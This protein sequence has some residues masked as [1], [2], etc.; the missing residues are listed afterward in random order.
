MKLNIGCGYE[1]LP[2]YVNIDSSRESLADKFM[3]A[4]R[5]EFDDGSAG[6]VRAAQLIEHLGFFKAKY[7]LA[8]C[9]R[10][11]K[12]GGLLTLETPHVEKTFQAFLKGDRAGREAALG[13]VYGSESRGMEHRWCFPEE[14]LKEILAEAGF[15]LKKKQYFEYQPGRP[16]IRLD[17]RKK[18][19]PAAD[20]RRLGAGDAPCFGDEYAASETEK[21]LKAVLAPGIFDDNDRAFELV[22]YE[23]RLAEAFFRVRELDKYVKA[24]AALGKV[25]FTARMYSALAAQ[26]LDTGQKEAFDAALKAGRSCLKE[27]LAGR[28]PAAVKPGPH[29]LFSLEMARLLSVRA[30]RAGLKVYETGNIGAAAEHFAAALR[31]DR[32]N[33]YTWLYLARGYEVGGQHV[34]CVL[35]YERSLALFGRDGF[36]GEMAEE[37]GKR[38]EKLR[39]PGR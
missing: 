5:L 34:K 35:A 33:P 11:L 15:E 10:V 32:D 21:L 31:L 39:R 37:I 23:P 4:H 3:E 14:L 12:D 25:N 6:E 7:F 27:A 26:P 19:R 30:F 36:A 22:L 13:W 17:A 28:P 18:S 38:L 8:E 16:V 20:R 9:Y 1:Y 24:A 29:P 2:G